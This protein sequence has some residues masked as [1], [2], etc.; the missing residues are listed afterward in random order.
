MTIESFLL[1]AQQQGRDLIDRGLDHHIR[2]AVTGLSGAGKTA[3]IT[4]LI[5]HFKHAGELP[6]SFWQAASR[7]AITAVE[8]T[9]QPDWTIARFDYEQAV[10]ALTQVQPCW[11]ESTTQMSEIRL[12]VHLKRQSGLLKN[13]IS[14]KRLV[15]DILDY[16][17][18]WLLDLPLLNLSYEQWSKQQFE[19]SQ[20]ASRQAEFKA[21]QSDCLPLPTAPN[22]ELI[23][24]YIR[25]QAARYREMLQ[26]LRNQHGL[27]WLQPGRAL[28]PGAYAQA[29][30]LDFFPWPEAQQQPQS[31][32]YQ[33][34]SERFERYKKEL[35]APMYERHFRSFNRQVMMV[36]ILGAMARGPAAFADLQQALQQLMPI[37]QYGKNHWLRRLFKPHIDRVAFVASKADYLLPEQQQ[38]VQQW[39]Q[40]LVEQATVEQFEQEPFVREYFA[41]ASLRVTELGQNQQQQL[42]LRGFDGENWVQFYLA[43]LPDSIAQFEQALAL[44]HLTPLPDVSKRPFAA[45]RM[46][47]IIEFLTR[48]E[49]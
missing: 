45:I 29:P 22:N 42:L 32:V 20:Q 2:I 38:L 28:L 47:Q 34:L 23:E 40:Q 21:W 13:I 17:G 49:V 7:G 44:P 10:Q 3:F 46:D 35:V 36:D 48:D 26:S 33:A 14:S 15:I 27:Y 43:D 25:T 1:K 6:V 30:I 31:P 4:S 19:L 9:P 5:D 11:P 24:H 18:E 37:F 16:P 8:F 41:M 39:L 12:T